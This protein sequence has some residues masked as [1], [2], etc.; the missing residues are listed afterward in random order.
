MTDNEIENYKIIALSI[1]NNIKMEDI[2][3]LIYFNRI[4]NQPECYSNDQ[5]VNKEFN[6]K[7]FSD[8][9]SNKPPTEDESE[10]VIIARKVFNE[11]DK[12]L[13]DEY[14]LE[15]FLKQQTKLILEFYKDELVFKRIKGIYD[16]IISPV[17]N[18]YPIE[19]ANSVI[20]K[21]IQDNSQE[22]D[23]DKLLQEI[24]PEK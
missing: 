23:I 5:L 15:N 21:Y 9:I 19:T 24:A 3:R 16:C 6:I 18:Q 20:E 12:L 14:G 10:N 7:F 1:E 17:I 2:D 4:R 11:Q 8:I 22:D 13:R